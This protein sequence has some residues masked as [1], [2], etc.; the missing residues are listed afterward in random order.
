LNKSLWLDNLRVKA[1]FMVVLIHAAAPG[2]YKYN[3]IPD[4]WWWICNIY[5]S[6]LRCCVPLFVMISGA[7]I[8]NKDYELMDF[9][10]K[11]FSKVAIPFIAWTIIY[12][13]FNH[14]Y[15][16]INYGINHIIGFLLFKPVSYHLWFV[17]MIISLYL[18]TPVLRKWLKHAND[19]EIIFFLLICFIAAF[20]NPIIKKWNGNTIGF[21]LQFFTGYTGYFVLGYYLANRSSLFSVTTAWT[22][23]ILG[24]L[25]TVFGTYWLTSASGKFDAFFFEYLT[26][27]VLLASAGL[28][29]VF[30]LHFNRV[31][32]NSKIISIISKA[33][34][35]IYFINVIFLVI[36]NKHGINYTFIHPLISIPLLT[37]FVVVLSVAVIFTFQKIPKA[38]YVT[39]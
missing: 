12:A 33:S 32:F 21:H 29:I 17:F 13:V 36:L 3:Q 1:T 25:A 11:R 5:D 20:I 9:L 22:L 24:A 15:L 30:K 38:N 10:K 31:I 7:L 35:G 16:G 26:P 2:L 28:F 27:N 14:Y 23:F 18:A 8:L 4:S 6:L 37:L 39:G 19:K 34:L